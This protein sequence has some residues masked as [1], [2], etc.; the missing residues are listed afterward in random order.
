MFSADFLLFL[1]YLAMIIYLFTQSRQWSF[2]LTLIYARH[3]YSALKPPALT[4]L[5]NFPK[6][7]L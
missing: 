4:P 7:T 2:F 3:K 6:P 1:E 5:T